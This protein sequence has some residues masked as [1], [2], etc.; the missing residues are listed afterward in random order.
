M[1][2]AHAAGQDGLASESLTRVGGRDVLVSV[3]FHEQ[4]AQV[5]LV[6]GINAN[7]AHFRVSGGDLPVGR[8][9]VVE[10]EDEFRCT[11]AEGRSLA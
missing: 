6:E 5:A 7:Y 3:L 11:H 9:H 1:W 4:W 8:F 10:A 2:R